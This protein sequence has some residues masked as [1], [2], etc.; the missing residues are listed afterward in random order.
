M[1]GPAFCVIRRL[2]SLDVYS[3]GTL[4]ALLDVEG[5]LLVLFEGAVARGVDRRVVSENVLAADRTLPGGIGS[6]MRRATV[7]PQSGS[8]TSKPPQQLSLLHTELI[9]GEKP[10]FSQRGEFGYQLCD[11]GGADWLYIHM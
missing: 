3:L 8:L 5:N 2:D 7:C 9:V 11:I 6:H 4:G 1:T 10:R